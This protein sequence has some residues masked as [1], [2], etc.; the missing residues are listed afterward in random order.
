[1]IHCVFFTFLCA[2]YICIFYK[3]ISTYLNLSQLIWNY[4]TN[5]YKWTSPI[6]ASMTTK[7]TI[8]KRYIHICHRIHWECLLPKQ[9]TT[10]SGGGKTNLLYRMLIAPMLFYERFFFFAKISNKAS[11]NIL[12]IIWQM[13]ANKLVMMS[14]ISIMMI[15]FQ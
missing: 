6:M 12:L 8:S 10:P 11:T 1:M 4:L 13:W 14:F 9:V 15:S 7:K 3:L 2:F 5:I